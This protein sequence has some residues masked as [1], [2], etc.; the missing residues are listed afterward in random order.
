MITDKIENA[1]LYY[2]SD[3]A[4]SERLKA[5]L[6]FLE[7]NDISKLKNGKHLIDGEDLY[8]SVHE[9]YT[10]PKPE[11]SYEVHRKYIDIQ[12]I[13]EGREKLGYTN[14]KNCSPDIPYNEE[15]DIEFI[16]SPIGESV[17]ALKGDF[18]IFW[19]EDAHMPSI[20]VD[21]SEYVKKAVIKARV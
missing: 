4:L 13:A 16:K 12:F 3:S 7:N 21:Q 6:K 11:D 1:H 19:P 15:R 8:I 14:I 20:P 2:T 9:Y 18:V 17:I 5:G 10:E